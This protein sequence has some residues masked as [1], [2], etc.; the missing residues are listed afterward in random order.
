MTKVPANE[1]KTRTK[2]L[3]DLFHSYEPYKKYEAGTKQTVLVTEISHDRKH[4][5]GHNKFYE[6]ILLPMHNNLLGKQVEVRVRTY[7]LSQEIKMFSRL[8]VSLP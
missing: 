8:V 5:V 2:R 3:T 4:Y 6:Q 1:V 7:V